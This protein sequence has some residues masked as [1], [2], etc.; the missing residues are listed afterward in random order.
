M[1]TPSG[2]GRGGR[3][4][5]KRCLA[6]NAC[7]AQRKHS[8]TGKNGTDSLTPQGGE[9]LGDPHHTH[10]SGPGNPPWASRTPDLGLVTAS[11]RTCSAA[12]DHMLV[13]KKLSEKKRVKPIMFTGPW[14]PGREVG[15]GVGRIS[16]WACHHGTGVQILQGLWTESQCFTEWKTK[17]RKESE[18]KERK[19]S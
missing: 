7:A 3:A 11:W 4:G 18:K 13:F 8:P 16:D 5:P 6:H 17:R 2:W 14:A 1:G 9:E 19:K 15:G 10:C 12:T